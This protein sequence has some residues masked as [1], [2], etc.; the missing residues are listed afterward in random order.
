MADD[1]NYYQ[2]TLARMEPDIANIDASAAY[3]SIAISLKRIADA[4]EELNPR[5]E[6]LGGVIEGAICRAKDPL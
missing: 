2:E 1:K 5:G 4:L 3:A 6:N